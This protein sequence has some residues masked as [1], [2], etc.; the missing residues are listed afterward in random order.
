[1]K[2]FRAV[3]EARCSTSSSHFPLLPGGS[4]GGD[5]LSF[6]RVMSLMTSIGG[7]DAQDDLFRQA[8]A[9]GLAIEPKRRGKSFTAKDDLLDNLSGIHWQR[10]ASV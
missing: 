3:P 1:M 6:G 10:P 7:S 2:L 5:T 8:S 4:G 9:A